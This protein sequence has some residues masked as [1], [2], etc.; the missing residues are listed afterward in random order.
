MVQTLKNLL[1]MQETRVWF[2]GWED[3]LEKGVAIHS[4]T[5]TWKILWKE[6]PGGLQPMKSQRAGRYWAT[7]TFTFPR[8]NEQL[9]RFLF[10]LLMTED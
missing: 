8:R 1:V 5:L 3:S 10:Y 7:D 2:L 6:E 9:E 4:S